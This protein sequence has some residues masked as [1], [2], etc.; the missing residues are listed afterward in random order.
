[1]DSRLGVEVDRMDLG[2]LFVSS[3]MPRVQWLTH[4]EY[5]GRSAV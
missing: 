5:M 4:D 2:V 3:D 1:M